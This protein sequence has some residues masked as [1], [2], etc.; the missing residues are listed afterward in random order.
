MEWE[1]LHGCKLVHC[2]GAVLCLL[3]LGTL[4]RLAHLIEKVPPQKGGKFPVSA[5]SL[6]DCA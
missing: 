2:Q 5:H 6:S 3:Q 4:P 1:R